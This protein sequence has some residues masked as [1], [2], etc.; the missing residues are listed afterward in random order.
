MLLS[1]RHFYLYLACISHSWHN[2]LSFDVLSSQSSFF[3]LCEE[4]TLLQGSHKVTVLCPVPESPS[5]RAG[6]K[7]QDVILRIDDQVGQSWRLCIWFSSSRANI[8]RFRNTCGICTLPARD[9]SFN[10]EAWALQMLSCQSTGLTCSCACGYRMLEAR[11]TA[12]MKRPRCFAAK[13]ARH[14]QSR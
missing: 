8:R 1:V 7:A 11:N 12:L 4:P 5:A 13:R 6:I 14:W 3:I 9:I 10:S 2:W